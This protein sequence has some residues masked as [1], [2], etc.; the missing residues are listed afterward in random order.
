MQAL[1]LFDALGDEFLTQLEEFLRDESPPPNVAEHA[2][3][4]AR[5]A[6]TNRERI[7]AVV[8]QASEH[9]A[10][11]RM[12]MVDRNVIRVAVCE[13]LY[14]TDVPAAVSIDEAVELAKSFGA[15]ESPGFVNG[16][17]DAVRK[18]N[19]APNETTV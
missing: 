4:L 14:H 3:R 5:D 2:A 12:Q 1:C 13:M 8:Q 19:P 17:L 7:D 18:M 16:I 9:W 15:A 6:W 10:T 11:T